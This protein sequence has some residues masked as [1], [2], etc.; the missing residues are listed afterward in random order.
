MSSKSRRKA[1]LIAFQTLYSID[2]GKSSLDEALQAA[3]EETE[4]SEESAEFA[5][6]LAAA[7]LDKTAELDEIISKYARGYTVDRLAAVD[8]TL[9]RLAAYEIK[10]SDETPA[11][12]A[13]N[14]AIEIAKKYST[15]E[16]GAFINGI[17][18][19]LVRSD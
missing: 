5:K 10:F 17:L 7:V 8:R 18:G 14:E 4:L 6:R 2:V 11:A 19:Q 13:I 1:R 3:F 15:A 9:L 16:S 12:V